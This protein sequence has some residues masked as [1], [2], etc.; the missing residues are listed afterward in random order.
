MK[1]RLRLYVWLGRERR[2]DEGEI[3]KEVKKGE[4][5]FHHETTSENDQKH[6]Q[7]SLE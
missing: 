2:N 6:D 3:V 5:P 4:K 7:A 1:L